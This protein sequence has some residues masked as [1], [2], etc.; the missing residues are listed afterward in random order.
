[1]D[2]EFINVLQAFLNEKYVSITHKH[3]DVQAWIRHVQKVIGIEYL[4]NNMYDMIPDEHYLAYIEAATCVS[5]DIIWMFRDVYKETFD[6]I[7]HIFLTITTLTFEET[8]KFIHKVYDHMLFSPQCHLSVYDFCSHKMNCTK[9]ECQCSHKSADV[10]Q[11]LVKYIA[12]QNNLKIHKI[13]NVWEIDENMASWLP[14]EMISDV[15][16]LLNG[17]QYDNRHALTIKIG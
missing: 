6:T 14:R 4:P 7:Y 11:T 1:M 2:S 9:G 13:W 15:V 17:N 16:Q 3:A 5:H 8:Y 10:N 12:Y